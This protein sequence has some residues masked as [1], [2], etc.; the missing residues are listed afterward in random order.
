[1]KKSLFALA[2]VPLLVGVALA[3]EPLNNVQP[4][5]DKVQPLTD[6][7]MDRVTAG[8]AMCT[9]T[10]T[11]IVSCSTGGFVIPPSTGPVNLNVIIQAYFAFLAGEGFPASP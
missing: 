6:T 3:A 4:L 9:S 10:G 2:A 8:A 11:G 1:M 5:S 7:Q